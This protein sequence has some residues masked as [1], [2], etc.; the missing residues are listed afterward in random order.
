MK[1]DN[2][3]KFCNKMFDD[4]CIEDGIMRHKIVRYTSQQNRLAERMNMSLIDKVRYILV[5][6][7]LSK[8]LWADVL[9]TTYYIV[10]KSPSSKIKFKTTI[11][12]WSNKPVGYSSMMVFSCP[13][14]AHIKQG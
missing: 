12:L 10:N 2:G 1:T 6:S 9:S 3:L 13:I 8:A 7:R 14:Y 5:H 11:K 4:F